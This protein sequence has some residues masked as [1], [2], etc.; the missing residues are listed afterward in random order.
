MKGTISLLHFLLK[1]QMI[2]HHKNLSHTSAFD[3]TKINNQKIIYPDKLIFF[4][5]EKWEE[6]QWKMLIYLQWKAWFHQLLWSSPHNLCI[7]FPDLLHFHS[8]GE[9][10][11]AECQCVWKSCSTWR[12]DSFQD[13]PWGDLLFEVHSVQ[14]WWKL[15]IV[16]CYCHHIH[17][18][19]RKFHSHTSNFY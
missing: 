13:D 17:R 4:F 16:L 15:A 6:K 10:F 18:W 12:S 3:N 5:C 11:L 2:G 19:F 8:G 9:R 1:L 14:L 7:L